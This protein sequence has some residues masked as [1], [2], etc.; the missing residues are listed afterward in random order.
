MSSFWSITLWVAF[1]AEQILLLLIQ[2]S[3]VFPRSDREI[4]LWFGSDSE[5]LLVSV[6]LGLA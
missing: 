2:T 1:V 4:C 6:A 5:H 3:G